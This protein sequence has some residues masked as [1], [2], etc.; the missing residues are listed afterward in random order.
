MEETRMKKTILF[1]G[2][3]MSSAL[4]LSACGNSSSDKSSEKS[5]SKSTTVKVP[6]KAAEY[7]FKDNKV[8]IRDLS[9][10]ITQTKVIPVGET[11]NEYGE[12]PVIAFWYKT[13]NKTNKEI[14]PGSAWIAVFKAVQDNDKNSVNELDMGSLPDDRFLDSQSENIKKDGT[15]ENAV[16]YELDDTTTPVKLIANQGIGGKDLGEQT[17]NLK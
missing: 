1:A 10:E 4:L 13:T 3:V 9:I 8:N 6:K 16:A 17:F 11:G 5:S 15:V 12:K 7:Y 2:V 14:D